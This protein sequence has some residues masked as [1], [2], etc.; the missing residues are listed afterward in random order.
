MDIE[1]LQKKR[2]KNVQE[3]N[4]IERDRIRRVALWWRGNALPKP[5][6]ELA[7]QQGINR[8]TAVLVE[9]G[10]HSTH[11]PHTYEGTFLT[12]SGEFWRYEIELDGEEKKIVEIEQ[13]AQV[14]MEVN[15]HK[16]GTG[17]SFGHLC[18]E[19]LDELLSPNDPEG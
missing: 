11:W 1:A 9:G 12:R 7:A 17:K 18:H 16:R 19:V 15:A 10:D 8:E 14:P 13:W 2:Q 3:Q 5:I 6:E 4:A